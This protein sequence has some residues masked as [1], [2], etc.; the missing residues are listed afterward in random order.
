MQGNR[1]HLVCKSELPRGN[2]NQLIECNA[3]NRGGQLEFCDLSEM[4]NR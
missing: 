2:F 3:V 1:Q 4:R